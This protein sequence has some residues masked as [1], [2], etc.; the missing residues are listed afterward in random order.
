[1]LERI[2]YCVSSKTH[3]NHSA[4]T[5]GPSQYTM[6]STSLFLSVE[7]RCR[8]FTCS[9]VPNG[10]GTSSSTMFSYFSFHV[11]G[12][13]Q[14]GQGSRASSCPPLL[15]CNGED[16]Y[17]FNAHYR[18][19]AHADHEGPEFSITHQTP[20]DIY[21]LKLFCAESCAKRERWSESFAHGISA[22]DHHKNSFPY[23]H[24]LFCQLALAAGKMSLETDVWIDM[25]LKA[26]EYD[27]FIYNKW[28]RW[29]VFQ[30][31]LVHH[32][33]FD[34][35]RKVFSHGLD[36]IH[37]KSSF[38]VQLMTNHVHSLMAQIENNIAFQFLRQTFHQDCLHWLATNHFILI[39]V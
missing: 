11:P 36:H 32:G 18:S 9:F 22:L 17:P 30:T 33:L 5:I 20:E 29:I 4:A 26:Q 7:S 35:E 2:G 25:L 12:V 6:H 27:E 14:L 23:L 13:T 24:N 8:T 21:Y 16:Y 38:R 37:L 28:K 34:L 31:L 3:W 19:E 39:T 1:M 10:M 15:L